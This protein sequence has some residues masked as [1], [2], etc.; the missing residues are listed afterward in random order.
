MLGEPHAFVLGLPL[1]DCPRAPLVVWDQSH[2]IMS[3]AFRAALSDH[4][5]QDWGTV[6]LTEVYQA[7]RRRVFETCK[8]IAL[9]ARRG[10]ATLLHRLTLHGVAP[11]GEGENASPARPILYFRP[12]LKNGR[13][14]WL[15][16]P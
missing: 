6:D 1:T 3:E 4:D 16:A 7:T 15:D 10:Q 9:P 11:W 2:Q 13:A 8:R 14:D 12:Y 5:P